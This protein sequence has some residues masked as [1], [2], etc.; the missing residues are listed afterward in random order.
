MASNTYIIDT[1]MR[2]FATLQTKM[3]DLVKKAETDKKTHT[4]TI[5]RK[6][7]D[8]SVVTE[9]RYTIAESTEANT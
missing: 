8:N 6:E 2:D 9:Y 5:S 3:Q 7:I 1:N 4:I